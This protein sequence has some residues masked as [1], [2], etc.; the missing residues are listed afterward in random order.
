MYIGFGYWGEELSL[1][2]GCIVVDDVEVAVNNQ[3]P[4]SEWVAPN[5]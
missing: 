3:Y 4:Y 5:K 2:K 1:S